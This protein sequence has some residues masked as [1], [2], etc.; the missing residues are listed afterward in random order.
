MREDEF[1]FLIGCLHVPAWKLEH[2]AWRFVGRVGNG[3]PFVVDFLFFHSCIVA[4]AF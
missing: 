1:F 4:S 3:I 2:R